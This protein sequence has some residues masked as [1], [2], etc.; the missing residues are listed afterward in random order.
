MIRPGP[1]HLRTDESI[2]MV[3][4]TPTPRV[5]REFVYDKSGEVR[6]SSCR[7]D[8][9]LEVRAKSTVVVTT[10]Y[11]TVLPVGCDDRKAIC[12]IRGHIKFS[13][14]LFVVCIERVFATVCRHH[15]TFSFSFWVFFSRG[16]CAR[17]ETSSVD[18]RQRRRESLNDHKTQGGRDILLLSSPQRL[19][20]SNIFSYSPSTLLHCTV[21]LHHSSSSPPLKLL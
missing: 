19:V 8:R 4:L 7:F 11:P 16:S 6:D 5:L 20:P 14:S 15:R 17:N 3:G 10:R 1:L 18:K 21:R 13:F 2:V 12:A 9:Y